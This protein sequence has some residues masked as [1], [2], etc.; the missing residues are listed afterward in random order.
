MRLVDG[1]AQEVMAASDAVLLASGTATLEATLV[2]RPMVV[3][4]RLAPLTGFL[5]R[6]LRLV[7]APYFSQPN[8][9]AG[10]RLVP[11]F[12][13]RRGAGRRARPGVLGQLERA[14]RAELRATF[15]A[16]H[17]TLRRNASARAADAILELL[18]VRSAASAH[19][20]SDRRHNADWLDIA[21]PCWSPAST[22]PGAGRSRVPSS[23]PR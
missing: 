7:K 2:K 19:V 22:K 16:I 14:D 6:R 4:Y 12:F 18:E 8:L 3:A 23:R 21:T 13:Q 15:R 1:H 11:E 5:L 9:L 20:E 17:E 10:R